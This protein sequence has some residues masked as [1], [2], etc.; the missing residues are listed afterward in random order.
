M[1]KI[2]T[3][4]GKINI[5]NKDD[6]TSF[7]QGMTTLEAAGGLVLNEKGEVLMIFRRGSWDLP[8]GKIDPN[9]SVETAAIR[10]VR[11]ET[12]L[13]ELKI[14]LKLQV[15]YHTYNID[16]VNY[17]KPTHW[18]KM[19]HE[20]NQELVPQTEEDITEITWMS[21]K[22]V[23]GIL[24]QTYSSIQELLENHFLV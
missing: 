7:S 14:V 2:H 6:L 10:E 11:E 24:D 17:I 23:E 5:E 12:G 1:Y 8:K 13:T 18:F 9:E 16:N 21:K 4:A 20:S 22:Q 19:I 3:P 15:T